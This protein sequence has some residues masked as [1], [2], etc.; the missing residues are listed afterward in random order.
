MNEELRRLCVDAYQGNVV[1]FS[2]K[3]TSE[4]I[5]KAF[6]DIIGTDK[7]DRKTFRRHKT[8][9][10]EILEV[11]LDDIIDRGWEDNTFFN[12][13]VEYRNVN[14]GDTNEFAVE[15]KTMLSVSK[16]A[17]GHWDLRRQRLNVGDTFRVETSLYGVKIY[18][19]FKRFIAGRIDWGELVEKIQ[20]AVNVKIAQ[21][22]YT[23]FMGAMEFLPTEFKTSG[24]FNAAA[25]HDIV[26][27]V[28]V[29]NNYA[30]VVIAGTRKALSKIT[31][32]MTGNYGSL[33]SDRMKEEINQTGATQMWDGIPLLEIPQV[34]IPNSFEFAI[35]D[36]K[37]IVLPANTK[38]I[39]F[40][41]EGESMIDEVT[42]HTQNKDMTLEYTFLTQFGIATVFNMYLGAYDLIG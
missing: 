38:P 22:I 34:H 37:L 30:P 5:R 14:F 21:E 25:M 23:N 35:D 28:Q 20:T 8:D 3:E 11:V 16:L 24:G 41:K 29:S 31:G 36:Q 2:E 42:D 4:V 32:S 10:F 18:A 7:I 12:Q 39:K 6:I 15:D 27:Q 17:D 9:I 26:D 19:E 40:V 1:N 13:F 33:L